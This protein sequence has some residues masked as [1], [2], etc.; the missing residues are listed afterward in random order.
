MKTIHLTQDE[1]DLLY[2]WINTWEPIFN[3]PD[4]EDNRMAKLFHN[5]QIKLK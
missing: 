1:V 3:P 4:S 5:I 2:Y